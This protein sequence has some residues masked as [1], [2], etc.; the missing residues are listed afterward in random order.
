MTTK[1]K[2]PSKA[3]TFDP[4]A[5][6]PAESIRQQLNRILTSSEFKATDVQKS[7][8]AFVVETTLSGRSHEIKGYTVATAPDGPSA[9]VWVFGLL[10]GMSVFRRR[11]R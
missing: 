11:R 5:V 7:F 10:V 2:I 9:L 4:N 8:L 3:T 1:D 6:P